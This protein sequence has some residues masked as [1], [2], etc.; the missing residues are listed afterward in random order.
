MA[1][2]MNR[3]AMSK[4]S[5]AI[6]I[7]E[8]CCT[9]WSAEVSYLE[10]D[11]FFLAEMYSYFNPRTQKR[12]NYRHAIKYARIIGFQKMSL[13][14]LAVSSSI[15]FLDLFLYIDQM[16]KIPITN[17]ART[18]S[19]IKTPPSVVKLVRDHF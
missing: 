19:A 17:I 13:F 18:P 16:P 11:S 9:F 5:L 10:G 12:S 7:R 1:T 2:V 15:F 6:V 14:N 8:N 4:E 3:V